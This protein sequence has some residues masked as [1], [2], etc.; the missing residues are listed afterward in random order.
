MCLLCGERSSCLEILVPIGL[1]QGPPPQKKTYSGHILDFSSLTRQL[2]HLRFPSN[3]TR[4]S[5]VNT[6]TLS[7]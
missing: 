4:G 2:G 1:T 5:E 7:T 3:K 6:P